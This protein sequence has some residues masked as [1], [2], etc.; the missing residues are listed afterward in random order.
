MVVH[1]FHVVRSVV[2][3]AEA[4]PPP[5]IDPELYWPV[6]SPERASS[7]LLGEGSQ[8]LQGRRVVQYREPPRRLILEEPLDRAS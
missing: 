7:L 5:A 3:P 2:F 4:Y 6:R 8:I 1:D